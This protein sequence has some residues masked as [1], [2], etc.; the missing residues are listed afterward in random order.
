MNKR[1]SLK[2]EKKKKFF[3]GFDL[4]GIE[5]N[6]NTCPKGQTKSKC[7][8]ETIVSPKIATKNFWI[9]ALKIFLAPWGLPGSFGGFL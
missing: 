6:K 5:S 3:A 4:S 7:P 8:Y 1:K 2:K 9:S